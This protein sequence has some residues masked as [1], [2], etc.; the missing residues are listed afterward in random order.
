MYRLQGDFGGDAAENID[1]YMPQGD[2]GGDAA[3]NIAVYMFT[4]IMVKTPPKE[5]LL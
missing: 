1:F 3:E 2:Y 5:R 4:V